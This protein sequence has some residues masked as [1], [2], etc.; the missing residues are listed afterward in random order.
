MPEQR[1]LLER[2]REMQRE[3]RGTGDDRVFLEADLE[4]AGRRQANRR[5]DAELKSGAAQ[6][7]LL[8]VFVQ[9][10]MGVELD[11]ETQRRPSLPA[12]AGTAQCDPSA[13][14]LA[15]HFASRGIESAAREI[16]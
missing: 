14:V 6:D 16:G 1:R 15:E 9:R 12:Q 2:Q 3:I 13:L 10:R 7:L 4:F 5:A 11:Q 8:H